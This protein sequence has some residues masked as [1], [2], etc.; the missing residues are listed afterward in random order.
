MKRDALT[1]EPGGSPPEGSSSARH[2][3]CIRHIFNGVAVIQH[4]TQALLRSFAYA[5]TVPSRIEVEVSDDA[6]EALDR[7]ISAGEFPDRARALE[8]AL[9]RL[10]EPSHIAASYRRAYATHP[11]DEVYGEAGLRLMEKRVRRARSSTN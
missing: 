5:S 4:R 7:A 2:R 3:E 8:E 10:L 9:R 1:T 6:L 11:E